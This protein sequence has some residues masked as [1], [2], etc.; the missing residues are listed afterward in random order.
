MMELQKVFKK[1]Y[2]EDLRRNIQITR[3]KHSRLTLLK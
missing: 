1:S 2:M 3:E